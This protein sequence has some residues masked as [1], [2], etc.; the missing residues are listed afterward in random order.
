MESDI[1]TRI[2]RRDTGVP[3]CTSDIGY[4][5]TSDVCTLEREREREGGR[6]RER[7]RER[8]REREGERER[9]HV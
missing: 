7:E 3:T 8:G 1:A 9:D 2:Y 6:E 5:P 4:R